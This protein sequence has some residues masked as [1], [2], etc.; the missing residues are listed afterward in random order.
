MYNVNRL[1][2]GNNEYNNPNIIIKY[3]NQ[4]I[5]SSQM[6]NNQRI[7]NYYYNEETFNKNILYNINNLNKESLDSQYQNNTNPINFVQNPNPNYIAYNSIP[8]NFYPNPPQNPQSFYYR[9]MIPSNNSYLFQNANI[10][11]IP[12][13]IPNKHNNVKENDHFKVNNRL[14]NPKLDEYKNGVKLDIRNCETQYPLTFLSSDPFRQKK[15][16]IQNY[17]NNIN[18]YIMNTKQI[19]NITSPKIFKKTNIK[20]YNVSKIDHINNL[21]ENLEKISKKNKSRSKYYNNEN[22]SKNDRITK[23]NY[24]K[25]N[26]TPYNLHKKNKSLMDFYN[27][28]NSEKDY[29][30]VNKVFENRN[31]ISNNYNNIVYENE[32]ERMKYEDQ[33][34]KKYYKY[35]NYHNFKEKEENQVNNDYT[36]GKSIKNEYEK[37][38]NYILKIKKFINH[39]EQYYIISFYN[40][41]YFFIEQ[42]NLYNQAKISKNI[43]SLLKRFQRARNNV[44]LKNIQICYSPKYNS[45]TNNN[46]NNKKN[47]KK[48]NRNSSLTNIFRKVYIPKKN[49]DN[50]EFNR[51]INKSINNISTINCNHQNNFSIG[52]IPNQYQTNNSFTDIRLNLSTDFA[53]YINNQRYINRDLS[54][55]RINKNYFNNNKN[56]PNSFN[57][58]NKNHDNFLQNRSSKNSISIPKRSNNNLNKKSMVYVKPKTSKL[59]LKKKVINKNN[60]NEINYNTNSIE[61]NSFNYSSTINNINSNYIYSNI[62]NKKQLIKEDIILNSQNN[63]F[64]IKNSEKL[65]SPIKLNS[66][67]HKRNIS[68]LAKEI[69]DKDNLSQNKILNKNMVGEFNTTKY[70]SY[71]NENKI[72]EIIGNEDLIEE[73]IIKDICTYDKK[74]WVFIKY[75]IS[76]RAKQNFLKMKIKR[77]NNVIDSSVKGISNK[78]FKP[79]EKEHTDSIKIISSLSVLK[80]YNSYN[81]NLEMKEISEEKESKDNS[82]S[83]EEEY[84]NNKLSNVVNILKEYKKQMLLYFYKYFFLILNSGRNKNKIII[85]QNQVSKNIL[86]NFQKCDSQKLCLNGNNTY[87]RN[88]LDKNVINDKKGHKS[89]QKDSNNENSKEDLKRNLFPYISKVNTKNINKDKD[90]KKNFYG[91]N[92]FKINDSSKISNYLD[93]NLDKLNNDE[94]LNEK[95]GIE[96]NKLKLIVM[97]K[98]EKHY[99]KVWKNNKYLKNNENEKNNDDDK[100]IKEKIDK[101]HNKIKEEENEEEEEEEEEVEGEEENKEEGEIKKNKRLK[102]DF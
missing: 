77:L 72:N 32:K 71:N 8:N 26:N 52:Y 39:L 44:Q 55:D 37:K 53:P 58:M 1:N 13:I 60:D 57:N 95:D 28:K 45:M 92:I 91:N 30:E 41:F 88:E 73:T 23:E 54:L 87:N 2:Y 79:L 49:I 43:D 33:I 27:N 51:N 78:E 82:N 7:D 16:Y 17:N 66:L 70:D 24:I 85:S 84:L 5:Q 22:K 19:E 69:I 83:Q 46:F 93:I 4:R 99:F 47:L 35:N 50:L 68:D 98:F 15:A 14:Q 59:R 96:K 12:N 34:K 9:Q 61:N 101:N 3:P 80:S 74:L 42:M 48:L 18:N 63:F 97:K 81:K 10:N 94:K 6:I 90:E 102:N 21:S 31:I 25:I 11:Y 62:F 29:I 89:N 75:I 65:R 20:N 86:N 76:P 100:N 40:Y 36:F 64:P 67:G 38:E 56:I